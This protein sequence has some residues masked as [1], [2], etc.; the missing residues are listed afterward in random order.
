MA[1]GVDGVESGGFEG[2]HEAE[3][4]ADA[5]ADGDGVEHGVLGENG[6]QA[7]LAG[8]DPGA[9]HAGD[10]AEDGTEEGKHNG[11]DEE[12][13]EDIAVLGAEGEA[14]A[15]LAGAFGDAEEEDVHDADAADEHGDGGDGG[16][17]A[18]HGAGGA[19]GGGGDLLL[20]LHGEVV[21]LIGVEAVAL[22]EEGGDL[23]AGEV[24]GVAV[25]DLEI[26]D[27]GVGA[28]GDFL[29]GGGVGDE[30]EVVLDRAHEGHALGGEHAD[31][32]EGEAAHADGFADGVGVLKEFFDEGLA[33]DG[34]LGGGGEFLFAEHATAGEGPGADLEVVGGLA[35]DAGGPVG[36]AVDDLALGADLG[37]GGDDLGDL[38]AEGEGVLDGEGIGGA[39][40]DG[41]AAEGAGAGEDEHDVFAEAADLGLDVA[42]SALAEA[43][44]GDDGGHADDH[45]EGGEEGAEK[46]TAQFLERDLEDGEEFHGPGRVSSGL[47]YREGG[48]RR[49]R[50]RR[51]GEGRGR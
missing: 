48:S 27:H 49:R 3:E 5:S 24:H 50:C 42:A 15:D 20:G 13:A 43:D 34:D 17:Q 14:E 40:A 1:E 8:E 12:L 26:D 51:R 18:G 6:G 28:A 45:T 10:D 23:A 7:G 22:A 39:A 25:D 37:A 41:D 31:N 35:V 9:E 19:G 46:A 33:D 30:D 11:L 38:V 44:E 29:K 2:G 4:Q 47:G 36:V 16:E 21:G 32:A